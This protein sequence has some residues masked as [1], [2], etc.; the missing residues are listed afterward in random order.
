MKNIAVVFAGG[1]GSR[2]YSDL[3]KQFLEVNEKPIIIQTL[4]LFEV[5]E[6]IDEIY[7]AC[8]EQYIP[9]LNDMLKKFNVQKVVRVF[10]GGASGQDSIYIALSEVKK[11]HDDAVV[12]IHDGV[13]PLVDQRTINAC[14]ADVNEYGSAITSTPV[15]ETPL[16]TDD[17]KTVGAMPERSKTYT[18]QAPQ[19]FMLNDILGW[20]DKERVLDEPYSGIVDSCGLA[21]KYGAKPHLTEGNR[22]NIKVTTMEDYLT[23]IANSTAQNYEQLFKL[24]ENK[25]LKEDK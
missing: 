3:P 5:N 23:L 11:D 19:C 10:P 16:F 8:I 2:M 22:G 14:I 13:R 1:V 17:G 12:L 21:F 24:T 7:I 20:H 18:A 25:R 15:F 9:L 4:E 6:K